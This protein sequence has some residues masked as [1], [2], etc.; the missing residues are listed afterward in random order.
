VPLAELV[1]TSGPD[2]AV[3]FLGETR[4]DAF[5]RN[6]RDGIVLEQETLDA[7]EKLA[8]ILGIELPWKH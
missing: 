5:E 2:G 6:T 7:L 8:S 4:W 1:K 3:R